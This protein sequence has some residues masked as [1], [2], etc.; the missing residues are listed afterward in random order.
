MYFALFFFLGYDILFLEV[1]NYLIVK[2][3]IIVYFAK[4]I[5]NLTG[6]WHTMESQRDLLRIVG[7]LH[8]ETLDYLSIVN[9]FYMINNFLSHNI[10]TMLLCVYIVAV[11]IVSLYLDKIDLLI[12][13]SFLGSWITINLFDSI[14]FGNSIYFMLFWRI[15]CFNA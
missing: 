5:G 12:F 15:G 7:D 6:E 8:T 2:L 4:N 3:R 10:N 11:G 9:E 14:V 1:C 13:S